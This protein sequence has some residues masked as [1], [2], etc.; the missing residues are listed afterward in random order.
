MKNLLL[1]FPLTVFNLSLFAQTS[2][3][4]TGSTNTSWGTSTNWSPNGVPSS[5]DYIVINSA[6]NNLTLTSDKTIERY[7]INSGMMNLNNHTLTVNDQLL[8]YGG[9]TTSGKIVQS[10]TN[11][12]TITNATVNCKLDLTATTVTVQYATCTDSVKIHQTT[13]SGSTW[14]RGNKFYGHVD[15]ENTSNANMN[16]GNNPADSCFAGLTISGRRI[17]LAYQYPYNY[18][19]EDVVINDEGPSG[20]SFGLA[21]GNGSAKMK[22]DGNI[23]INKSGVG[24]LNIA[25]TSGTCEL[26]QTSGNGVIDGSTGYTDGFLKI[27]GLTQQGTGG[28]VILNKGADAQEFYLSEGTY[29]PNIGSLTIDLDDVTIDGAVVNAPANI[30]ANSLIVTN[31]QFNSSAYLEKKG[32]NTNNNGGNV[33]R[34]PTTIVQSGSAEMQFAYTNPDTAFSTLQLRTTTSNDLILGAY[35]EFVAMGSIYC[36]QQSGDI[37]LGGTSGGDF[38]VAGLGV[39]TL[40]LEQSGVCDVQTIT[41]NKPSGY[42]RLTGTMQVSN[43]MV[44]MQGVIHAVD[45]GLVKV[46][47]N[48]TVSSASDASHVQ[49]PVEKVGNDGFSFPIGRN[50]IYQP[51]TISAPSSTSHA[52]RAEYFDEDSDPDYIHSNRDGSI[53][54]L[55]RS[56]Y[57]MFN[58]IAGTGN[59]YVTLGWRDVACGISSI[60]DP[61]VCAWNGTQWKNLGNGAEAGTV[62]TGTA[63]T[64]KTTSIYGAYTWGN[65]SGLSA[66]AGPDRVMVAGDTVAIGVMVQPDWDYTWVPSAT[67]EESDSAIT[68]AYPTTKTQYVLEVTGENSCVATDTLVVYITVLPE[69]TARSSL[70]FVVNNG[71][72]IDTD[73]APR[74]DVG[75]YSHQASPMMYCGDNRLSFVHAKIDTVAAIPDTLA[76]V[77]I[78]FLETFREAEPL[79]MGL[80]SHH[81]NYY[82]A[83][84]PD[85]VTLT[86]SYNRVVYPELY[87]NTDLHI[88]GNNSWM[89]FEFVIHPGG[90]PEDI[91]MTFEGADNVEVIQSLGLLIVTSSI[92]TYI[93]PKPTALKIDTVGAAVELGWQ[94]DWDLSVTGDTVRFVNIGSYNPAEVLIFTLG[95]EY[96]AEPR[97]I[98]NPEWSTQ[99]GGREYDEGFSLSLDE[100]GNLYNCGVTSS[101]DFP[102]SIGAVFGYNRGGEDAYIARFGSADGATLGV[103]SNADQLE[104]TTYWGGTDNDRAYAS[105]N[106]GDGETGSVYITGYTS[107]LDFSTFNETGSYFDGSLGGGQD[108]FLISLDNLDGGILGDRWSTY[109]GGSGNEIGRAIAADGS[110]NIYVVGSTSTDAYAS[111]TCAVPATGDAGFPKCNTSSSYDNSVATGGETDGFIARFSTTG[112]LQWSS[113]YGGSAFDEIHDLTFDGTGNL[114]ITGETYSASGFPISD[115]G[116]YDQNDHGGGK[117]AFIGKFTSSLVLDFC[118]YYGGNG[119]DAGYAIEIDAQNNIYVAG[120]TSSSTAACSTC[121]CEVPTTGHFPQCPESGG[122]FQGNSVLGLGHYRGGDSDGFFAKFN[123][124]LDLTWATYYGGELADA[125]YDLDIEEYTDRLLFC[126]ESYSYPDD[127]LNGDLVLECNE[128]GSFWYK[129][130]ERAGLS[131]GLFGIF[132][133]D[134][135]VRIYSTLYGMNNLDRANALTVYSTDANN[136]F[137]YFTGYTASDD[138]NRYAS[139]GGGDYLYCCPNAYLTPSNNGL[140]GNSFLVRFSANT[141]FMSVEDM[142]NV[143]FA[144]PVAVY[145]NPT[146]YSVTVEFEIDGSQKVQMEIYSIEGRRMQ[147]LNMGKRYGQVREEIDFTGFPQ[148]TYLIRVLAGDIMVT[149]KVIKHG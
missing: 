65:F 27:M 24:D 8:M 55:D 78:H 97:H 83:H 17:R 69:D 23:I 84:C 101:P 66:D 80:N 46:L 114:F 136:R 138:F 112:Q 90:D 11:S 110:G 131:D 128:G 36:D 99:F 77:D 103:V 4:W 59:V 146:S 60:S 86:P 82:Y 122:Y 88:K 68:R 45:T 14:W 91:L 107:S 54:Y 21:G 108:A 71:Q 72:I 1:L 148:G 34:G 16:M 119:D 51:L 149:K 25:V 127:D 26:I 125:I 38:I 140:P 124:S 137:Y 76:R 73:G 74:P 104:W 81:Y 28:G 40:A 129:Q 53:A 41:F 42:A 142:E 139:H 115:G 3:T 19:Q 121:L 75:I 113:F 100:D 47:D 70:D 111:T 141:H 123:P 6:S 15:V 144:F 147:T 10:A 49:G 117:D 109:F 98:S 62:V 20:T 33:F 89:K 5:S 35:D 43:S 130:F 134:P 64:E 52:F 120:S 22:V 95:E 37:I 116:G 87:E 85:G 39:Q 61:D 79:G 57:W 94:P 32:G 9:T 29:G 145:P 7:R 12:T 48:T 2:Y 96:V 58:R 133:T 102:T 18:V 44:L 67:V 132:E 93:F 118:S 135:S 126:G 56:Q 143:N 13:G 63:R 105:V 30:S 92:G 106:V 31:N 50:G